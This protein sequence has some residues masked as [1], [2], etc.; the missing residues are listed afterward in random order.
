MRCTAYERERER[1][2]KQ[3]SLLKSSK[4]HVRS[5]RLKKNNY[6]ELNGGGLK[7]NHQSQNTNDMK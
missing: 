6:K 2:R 5:M 7:T 1:E 4:D 3:E